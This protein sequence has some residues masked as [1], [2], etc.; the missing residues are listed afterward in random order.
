M[1]SVRILLGLVCALALLPQA[2]SAAPFTVSSTQGW[3]SIPANLTVG[4]AYNISYVS[5]T[6]TVDTRNWPNVGIDGYDGTLDQQIL[7]VGPACK[8]VDFEPFG[9]LLGMWPGANADRIVM[10]AQTWNG[11]LSLRINDADGCLGDNGGSI[12][13]DISPVAPSADTSPPVI[14]N[15]SRPISVPAQ[16]A[17]GAVVNYTTPT[18]TDNVDPN[19]TV[20]CSPSSGSPFPVGT[21]TVTCTAQDATGNQA[22]P[23]TL[24]V[25]VT[26]P[27]QQQIPA[28]TTPPGGVNHLRLVPNSTQ[29]ALTW[30]A[31]A[32]ADF[33]HYVVERAG[34]QYVTI[35][36][37]TTATFTDT[38]LA[39]NTGYYYRVRAV[40]HAGN[41][42][43]AAYAS[44]VLHPPS[45]G[46]ANV[47]VS[48]TTQPIG[49]NGGNQSG[50]GVPPNGGG[51]DISKYFVCLKGP[52]GSCLGV[53]TPAPTDWLETPPE[54]LTSPA[55]GACALDVAVKLVPGGPEIKGL[56]RL[57]KSLGSVIRYDESGGK[58]DILVTQ[59]MITA[60]DSVSPVPWSCVTLAD[61]LIKYLTNNASGAPPRQHFMEIRAAA[62]Y[63]YRWRELPS[64]QIQRVKTL[65]VL[66]SVLDIAAADYAADR[67]LRRVYGQAWRKASPKRF[68]SRK[69][70]EGYRCNYVFRYR[71]V[72]HKGFVTVTGRRTRVVETRRWRARK[73]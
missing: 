28:D 22:N 1:R 70:G 38:G 73:H 34:D 17:N 58:L 30:D 60:Y 10:G 66:R 59:A 50:D 48:G 44:I 39:Y 65:P 72:W 4:Q 27:T 49:P 64:S 8:V 29:V 23:A 20:N 53:E 32:G 9:T 37:P 16:D 54:W 7:A 63:T 2:A 62:D 26:Q 61:G 31:V 69:H 36:Q 52:G 56:Y 68:A 19:V 3:Q 12:T 24:T 25:T 14:S 40:D 33:D 67:T 21:T 71:G 13:V 11:S 42:G 55:V 45:S 46:Q 6:W 47:P 43:G 35:G 51:T 18:A 15:V 5:G 41:Y 57:V